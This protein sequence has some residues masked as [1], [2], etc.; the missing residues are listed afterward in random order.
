LTDIKPKNNRK[1]TGK[2]TEK[3]IQAVPFPDHTN[4]DI[5]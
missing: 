3:I 5:S 2:I 4:K 1:N